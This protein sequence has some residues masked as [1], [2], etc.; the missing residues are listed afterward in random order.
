MEA[1]LST[2][3]AGT[4]KKRGEGHTRRDEILWAAKDLFLREGYEATTIRRIAEVVGVSAP[5]LYLYFK[6]KE[7]ILLALCDQTFGYLLEQMAEI[8]KQ[9]LPPI[10]RLRHCGDAYVR[11]ALNNPREYWLTFMSGHTPK[12]ISHQGGHKP[13][14]INP[15]QPGANGAIAFSRLMGMFRDIENA[16]MPLH[17]PVETAAELVWM[18]LHGLAAAIINNPEFPW[19]KRDT[20]IAGMIDMV[21][22]GVVRA[23]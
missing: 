19:T 10:E 15:D 8:E 21:V 12:Q 18:S 3:P 2:L 20:L 23:V 22:R 6:D 7:A 16:G 9:G 4:R 17:Y 1:D 13:D 11:F 14:V 5:A